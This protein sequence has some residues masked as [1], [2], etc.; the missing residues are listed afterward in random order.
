MSDCTAPRGLGTGIC[1]ILLGI[2]LSSSF[3]VPVAKKHLF[4]KK[5]KTQKINRD[6]EQR[7]FG[8]QVHYE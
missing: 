6:T 3:K 1:E 2:Q 5:Q 8:V 7:A 4:K